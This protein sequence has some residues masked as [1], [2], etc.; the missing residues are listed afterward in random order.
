VTINISLFRFHLSCVCRAFGSIR[1]FCMWDFVT[2]SYR[3]GSLAPRPTPNLEDQGISLSLASP[4]KSVRH[5]WPFQHLCL[6]RNSFRVHWCTQAPSLSNKVL[7]TRW[8]Y[9]REGNNFTLCGNL[10]HVRRNIFCGSAKSSV[11]YFTIMIVMRVK[12]QPR[13]VKIAVGRM[14]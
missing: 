14:S 8:R 9:H 1:L 7:S 5:G 3:V 11:A 12:S 10:R 2:S 13:A 6:R 4:L